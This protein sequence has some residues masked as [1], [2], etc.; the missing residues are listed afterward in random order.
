KER[1]LRLKTNKPA[2]Q[3]E[4]RPGKL[5]AVTDL[6]NNQDEP[7]RNTDEVKYEG[8]TIAEWMGQWDTRVSDDIDAAT[9]ALIKIGR[10]AVPRLIEEVKRRSNH[11]W[12]AVGVLSK[13]GPEAED[14]V[15]WL[16]EAGLDKDLRFGDGRQSTTAYRGSVLSS[17]SRMTWARDRVL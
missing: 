10:P 11:G 4:V 2:V 8:R 13:M 9:N 17:L 1:T 7:E 16:I 14:A 3:V 15:E 5:S 12:R 6:P